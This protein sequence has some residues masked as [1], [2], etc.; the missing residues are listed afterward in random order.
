MQLLYKFLGLTSI[1]IL[2]FFLGSS[3]QSHLKSQKDIKRESKVLIDLLNL[4]YSYKERSYVHFSPT[5]QTI[6]DMR[7][8]RISFDVG[9]YNRPKEESKLYRLPYMFRK[10]AAI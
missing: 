9:S 10:A 8:I 6:F 4:I 3:Y 5:T 7:L 1:G 2:A